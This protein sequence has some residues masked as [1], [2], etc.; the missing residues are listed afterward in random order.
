MATTRVQGGYT[1]ATGTR[2]FS[3][4]VT[5][6]NLLV[7]RVVWQG[8][9]GITLNSVTDTQGNTWTIHASTLS[10]NASL[11]QYVQIA[12]CTAGSSAANTVTATLSSGT[13]KGITLDEYN[14]SAGTLV[15]DSG[16][17]ATGTGSTINSGD[18]TTASD[19]GL[20]VSQYSA[21]KS[22][23]GAFVSLTNS[24]VEQNVYTAY[25]YYSDIHNL[26]LGVA[27]TESAGGTFASGSSDWMCNIAAFKVSGDTPPPPASYGKVNVGGVWKT[28]SAAHVKVAGAWKAVSSISV[29]VGGTW[30]PLA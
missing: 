11:S 18:I 12:S 5:A 29:N 4:N 24:F 17:S 28:A 14:N 9:A 2:A 6:G 25:W 19:N 26:D 16:T 1:A 27:G 21:K 3:S 15:F 30:K 13:P 7:A 10:Y 8:V 23:G 22:V 20:A